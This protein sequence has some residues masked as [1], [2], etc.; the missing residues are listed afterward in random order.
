VIMLKIE[1]FR[2][3]DDGKAVLKEIS[4]EGSMR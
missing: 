1:N 2:A 4:L 3:T